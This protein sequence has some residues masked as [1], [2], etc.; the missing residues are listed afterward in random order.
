MTEWRLSEAE[1][2]RLLAFDEILRERAFE[3]AGELAD[4]PEI[5]DRVEDYKP[6]IGVSYQCPKCWVVRGAASDLEVERVEAHQD[7]YRCAACGFRIGDDT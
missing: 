3:A 7:S 6:V 5:R 1:R 4:H 2:R